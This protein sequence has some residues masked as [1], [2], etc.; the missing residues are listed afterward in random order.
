MY[1]IGSTWS[2]QKSNEWKYVSVVEQIGLNELNAQCLE[3]GILSRDN[4][5]CGFTPHHSRADTDVRILQPKCI[6]LL[7]YLKKGTST[8][9][10]LSNTWTR[11]YTR[12]H[13]PLCWTL[14]PFTSQL[15]LIQVHQT[16][17]RLTLR[18]SKGGWLTAGR[19][20]GGVTWMVK[21]CW[22]LWCKRSL[23]RVSPS[24]LCSWPGRRVTT[25]CSRSRTCETSQPGE[26]GVGGGLWKCL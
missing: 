24:S 21:E 25:S 2:H 22:V 6:M 4:P 5:L 19:P 18:T 15:S 17:G 3:T 11:A 12:E 1:F 7:N 20:G 9:H 14:S 13:P 26:G 23:V 16:V 10:L 8:N